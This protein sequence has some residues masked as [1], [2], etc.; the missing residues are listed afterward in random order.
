MPAHCAVHRYYDSAAA[1]AALRR[2][3][4]G[5]LARG[6]GGVG[7]WRLA[8]APFYP[9]EN[10][11]FQADKGGGTAGAGAGAASGAG[12]KAGQQ[13]QQPEAVPPA[14]FTRE[15]QWRRDAAVRESV[16]LVEALIRAR[17]KP[18][19]VAAAVAAAAAAV[20][21]TVAQGLR[22]GSGGTA[23]PTPRLPLPLSSSSLSGRWAGGQQQQQQQHQQ[24]HQ[25]QQQQLQEVQAQESAR[26]AESV[27][28]PH[29]PSTQPIPP[30][31]LEN[32][33]TV[34]LSQVPIE[35]RAM[36]GLRLRVLAAARVE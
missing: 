4:E 8:V 28:L 31:L 13:P 34:T 15:M 25:Q 12:G 16:G 35:S 2:Q 1:A 29:C 22:S 5:V 11:V 7:G 18:P 32:R 14:K 33:K 9:A 30:P 17:L 3:L 24:Q 19:A 23:L 36:P 21:E 10:E 20:G 26:L 6:E 27:L